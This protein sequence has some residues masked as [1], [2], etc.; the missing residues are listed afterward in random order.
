M[1]AVYRLVN[2][3]TALPLLST[4]LLR[5]QFINLAEDT[6]AFLAGI[7]LIQSPKSA[8]NEPRYRRAALCHAAAFLA[9]HES[10]EQTVDFQTILPALL[11]ALQDPDQSVREAANECLQLLAKLFSKK[12]ATGVYGFDTIYGSHSSEEPLISLHCIRA[13]QFSRS[14]TVPR[15][16]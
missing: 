15:L 6:L 11:L 12:K 1:R 2:S 14:S 4:A 9:A 8:D 10:I 5:A 13:H 3:S 7:W 16:V